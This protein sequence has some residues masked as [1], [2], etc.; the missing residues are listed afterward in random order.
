MLVGAASWWGFQLLSSNRMLARLQMLCEIPPHSSGLVSHQM[1]VEE[2]ILQVLH[3]VTE[4]WFA[5]L[6]AS[7]GGSNGMQICSRS[8]L[9]EFSCLGISYRRYRVV[10]QTLDA[11]AKAAWKEVLNSNTA[12]DGGSRSPSVTFI[13]SESILWNYLPLLIDYILLHY[14]HWCK[15]CPLNWVNRWKRDGPT[16]TVHD[17]FHHN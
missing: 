3:P 4:W 16:K 12:V 5:L 15:E 14:I 7:W 1:W 8:L 10:N 9:P 11:C 13:V 2:K 6:L 17:I